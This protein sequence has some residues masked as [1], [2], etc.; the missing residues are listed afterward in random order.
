[1]HDDPVSGERT[2][3]LKKITSQKKR[4]L[5]I[6]LLT[7]KTTGTSGLREKFNQVC[8]A[9]KNLMSESERDIK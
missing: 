5:T 9:V 8:T 3:A 1:M 6:H 2:I 4:I 7:M